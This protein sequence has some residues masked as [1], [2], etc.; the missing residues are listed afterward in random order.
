VTNLLPIRVARRDVVQGEDGRDDEQDR[1]PEPAW[2]SAQISL[3][4]RRL[5]IAALLDNACDRNAVRLH[6]PQPGRKHQHP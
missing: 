1:D 3:A 2:V 6:S 4:K 5:N